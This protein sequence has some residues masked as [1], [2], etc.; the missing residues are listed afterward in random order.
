MTGLEE[1]VY[2]VC[3]DRQG[4]IYSDR[5]ERLARKIDGSIAPLL[6]HELDGRERIV[7]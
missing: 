7:G 4:S 1:M 3:D 5:W 6:R 2:P